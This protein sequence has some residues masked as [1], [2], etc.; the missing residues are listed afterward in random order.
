MEGTFIGDYVY[1]KKSVKNTRNLL[2]CMFVWV[3]LEEEKYAKTEKI[4]GIER[5]SG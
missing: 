3:C 4:H 1:F 5:E 2:I